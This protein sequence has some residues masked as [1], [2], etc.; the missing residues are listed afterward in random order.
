MA[1]MGRREGK[2]GSRRGNCEE[3]KLGDDA[4]WC[5]LTVALLGA[6]LRNLLVRFAASQH[7]NIMA[8]V[9]YS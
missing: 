4:V 2:E 9:L 3:V 1:S 7:G 6:A 8:G 5:P